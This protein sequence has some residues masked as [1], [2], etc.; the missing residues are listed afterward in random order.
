MELADHR[1]ILFSGSVYIFLAR[2]QSINYNQHGEK[3]SCGYYFAKPRF[4][5]SDIAC[6]LLPSRFSLLDDYGK[7][8]L[9]SS[10][11][12]CYGGNLAENAHKRSIHV[13]LHLEHIFICFS[14]LVS[15]FLPLCPSPCTRMSL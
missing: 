6:H 12:T 15:S 9:T 2:S 1:S 3:R 10:H 8:K 4:T 14:S 11:V 13:I 7:H 5:L